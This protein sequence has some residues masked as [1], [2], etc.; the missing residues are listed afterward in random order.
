GVPA[1]VRDAAW[2]DILRLESDLTSEHAKATIDLSTE[3]GFPSWLALGTLLRG[4]AFGVQGQVEEGVGQIH[5]GLAAWRAAGSEVWRSRWL[6]LLAEALGKGGQVEAG[7]TAVDEA[8]ACVE[9]TEE[10]SYEAELHRLQGALLLQ[11]SPDNHQ[12]ADACFH[13]A[14]KVARRQ[15]AKSWELRAATS[16]ARLWQQQG[17]TAEAC[18]LL[19]PVYGWFTEGF[20]TADLQEAKALLEDLA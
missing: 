12:K 16:L 18:D 4:W 15:E 19:A 10:R 14:L 5:D 9:R 8:L 2:L 7:L 3:Q 11:Q 17:K 6:V 20:E 1:A 13:Q